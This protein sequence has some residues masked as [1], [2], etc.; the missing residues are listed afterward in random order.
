MDDFVGPPQ[1]TLLPLNH[2]GCPI[3]GSE[4]DS[5]E[6]LND[7]LR[8][9][10]NL[11]GTKLMC[12]VGTCGTCIV[13][14]TASDHDGYRR[15]YSVN[16]CL[17]TILQCQD[18]EITTIEGIGDRQGYHPLQRTLAEYNGTQ[19]GYCSPGWVMNMYSSLESNDYKMT[20]CEI[21][22]SF[23]SNNCRCTGYRPILDAFKSFASD[24]PKPKIIDI[25][26]LKK[27]NKKCDP[28]DKDWCFIPDRD[29]EVKTIH[30][31]D[32]KVWYRVFGVS[33]IFDIW[34]HE[35]ESYMLVN[36]NTGRGILPIP[37]FPKVLID[38]SAV[39]VLKTH[40][41]D[42]N[43][44]IGA[45]VTLT[46]L[47]DIFKKTS[48]HYED[49]SYLDKVCEHLDL[50]A[51]VPVRNIATIGGNLMLKHRDPVFPS[52]VFLLLEAIGAVITIASIDGTLVATPVDFLLI[53]MRKKIITN[54]KIPPLSRHFHF[55]SF[56][57]MPRSQNAIAEINGAFLYELDSNEKTVK[58]ARIVYG[59]LSDDFIHA[60]KTET[61]LVGK[62]LFQNDTLQ[63]ALIILEKEIVAE[64]IKAMYSPEYRK[65]AALGIFYK[66]L[67]SLTPS[68]QLNERYASGARDLRKTR[69][70]SKGTEV[71]DTNPILWPLNEPM[72][73][74]EALIQCSG[75]AKYVDDLQTQPKEVYCAFVTAK[76]FSGEFE[77]VDP[78]PALILPG[79]IAF[80]SAKDIPGTNSFISETVTSYQREILLSD[81]KITFYDQPIGIIVAETE[82]LAAR[83]AELVKVTYTKAQRKPLL[84]IR[85]VMTED[86]SRITLFLALPA[87]EPPGADI[88]KVIKG[89]EDIFWQYHY[90]METQSCV[91][92]PNED[93]IDVFPSSQ[94]LDMSHL[95]VANVLN[96]EQ[97]RVNVVI[98]RCGGAYGS[99]ISRSGLIA[100]ACSLV[101]YLLNRPCRFI[102]DFQANMRIIGKRTP[103]HFEYE[104][105]V[106]SD[107]E[108]QYLNY[109]I[110]DDLG[111]KQGDFIGFLL[112]S[113]M[114]NCY[115]NRR[116][117]CNIYYA[118]T[119]TTP[120]TY[121]RSPGSLEAIAMTEHV[122]ERISY[123]LD[124]DPIEVRSKNLKKEEKEIY[125]VLE[126]LI[127]D[128]EYYKRK[129]E[130]E[131]F[132]KKNRWIK[133]GFRIATM[134]WP[135]PPMVDFHISLSVYHGDGSV[136]VKHGGIELGQ[137]INT[138]VT[139]AIAFV[140][141]IPI[142]K[143]KCRPCESSS[144]PN[145]F[146]TAASRTTQS[147]GF[148]AI[149]CC[150]IILD[151]LSAVRVDGVEDPTWEQLIQAAYQQGVNLQASYH[152]TTADQEAHRSVGAAAAEVELD[153]L[154][155]ESQ[156]LRVDIVE[157]VGTSL[158]PEIDVG[159][160]EGAFV[161]GLGYWTSEEIKFNKDTGEIQ[162]DL[163]TSY[164]IPLAKDIP[165]DFRIKLLRNHNEIGTL[166]SRCVAEPAICLS[167][168]VAF[169]LKA[170][171][172]SSR[173]ESGFPRNQWFKNDGPYT[174]E[175][176]VMHSE[177]KVEEFLYK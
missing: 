71:Y 112:V 76:I 101:T 160:I 105:A 174:L 10:L 43:L 106:S 29:H 114:R 49:F 30:L 86:P 157:D 62:D 135:G 69:P 155:G 45:G 16:S 154:T 64:E 5:D 168:C 89:T 97:S 171:I 100:T 170:A 91:T 33:D 44:V 116:W 133:R 3:A 13:A 11:R 38:I 87:R 151:R 94:F 15:T 1:C 99:K 169:A 47:I 125:Q 31:K 129:E 93:G 143:I 176:N 166:G 108:I 162:N 137:G 68:K 122:F 25:E 119:D 167:V 118:F 57:V 134:S 56:K 22:N 78:S 28:C 80:Y 9:R 27:C 173:E 95:V 127:K 132:N 63:G 104:V 147:V 34:R 107:G 172:L 96:I 152:V 141:K 74:L 2:G 142:S 77:N 70:L 163:A 54:I 130:V 19:C 7:F 83:A 92:R 41:L 37:E 124:M 156:I 145:N 60:S 90:T 158:N 79:V 175:A 111:Y 53:D 61:F 148:G 140:F 84:D 88:D 144:I 161:M 52:D 6:T 102:M 65:K 21:E 164:H 113:A 18:L 51:H 58:S 48:E 12:K 20:Q 115:N 42:Q 14:A 35:H 138:K 85:D 73:K 131:K 128:S 153:I 67:L 40:Y 146:T 39:E 72:P 123:E 24:A 8:K 117:N 177:A 165:I 121:A 23:G 4:V 103:S 59:G 98:P 159:Q 81:G 26:D 50:V 110:Y 75:E 126:T 136:I 120:N 36:G 32:D 150:Q 17:L 82:A 46:S 149:K 66:G 109:N 139:Q 55:V